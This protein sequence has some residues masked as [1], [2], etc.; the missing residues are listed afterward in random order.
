MNLRIAALASVL[1]CSFCVVACGGD[2]D[3]NAANGGGALKANC[4]KVC[5]L[6]APLNCP[7]DDAANCVNECQLGATASEKCRT[8]IEALIACE[9]ARTASDFECSFGEADVKDTVCTAEGDAVGACLT[10]D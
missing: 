9:A 8:T 6:E 1:V 4:E 5:V 3:D 2:D 7:D 10:T